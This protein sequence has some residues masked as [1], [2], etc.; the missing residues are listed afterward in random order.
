MQVGAASS[1]A[2]ECDPWSEGGCIRPNTSVPSNGA[3]PH[4]TVRQSMGGIRQRTLAPCVRAVSNDTQGLNCGEAEVAMRPLDFAPIHKDLRLR[5]WAGSS[6]W[7]TVGTRGEPHRQA[8]V[9]QGPERENP[10]KSIIL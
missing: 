2:Q 8:E 10:R 3:G 6:N 4:A 5:V 1:T 7:G 9:A